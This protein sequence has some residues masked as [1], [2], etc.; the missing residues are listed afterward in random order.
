MEAEIPAIMRRGLV[1]LR[2]T[3]AL[4]T[5]V[6]QLGQRAIRALWPLLLITTLSACKETTESSGPRSLRFWSG[7]AAPFTNDLAAHYSAKVPDIDVKVEAVPGSLVVTTSVQEHG[8][9]GFAQADVV[10]LAYR[11][12]ING[13]EY[14][15]TNLRG[16]AV[17]WVNNVYV[18]VPR[19]SPINDVSEL[20][21]KR[22]GV[23]RLGGSG[24]FAARIVLRV[25]GLAYAD[26]KVTFLSTELM[27]NQL[28]RGELDAAVYVYPFLT[29]S[30]QA[31]HR[32]FGIRLLPV[33]RDVTNRLL[34]EY[35]FL[36][37]VVV[38]SSELAGQKHDVD[39]LGAQSLL[40]CRSD[41]SEQLAYELTREFF[42]ALP[43][44]ARKHP[45]AALIDPE[46]APTTPIPLHPGA[47]RYY[48][49][50]EILK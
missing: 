7:I 34:A 4:S 13:H 6:E 44:L 27:M 33:S 23:L 15:H 24:E 2:A 14:P 18:I 45:V 26:M 28:A 32:Q 9:L 49:E 41:L 37:R 3:G 22:V 43:E 38:P 46:Q 10:Y 36:E 31:A 12:G 20:R 19:D 1:M 21:T 50:R 16:V 48:R 30:V 5:S 17:L 42:V 39:T 35:P 25:Y 47:A 40:I 8:D 11:H 29:E